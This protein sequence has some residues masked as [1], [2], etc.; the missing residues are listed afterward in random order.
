MWATLRDLAFRD[1]AF[2]SLEAVVGRV[3][4]LP[5][6]ISLHEIRV[7]DEH[8]PTSGAVTSMMRAAALLAQENLIFAL[9]EGQEHH[10]MDIDLSCFHHATSIALE[11]IAFVLRALVVEGEFPTL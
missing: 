3:P 11:W 2:L 6:A 7:F 5:P 8:R 4:R 9:P 1:I 10:P